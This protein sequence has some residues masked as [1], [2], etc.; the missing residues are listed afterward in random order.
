MV[1]VGISVEGAT[2]ERFIK[3]V[4][5]PYL[6]QKQIELT[7]INLKGNVSLNKIRSELKNL[8]F[9]F[10][11]VSTFYDFYGFNN[12]DPKETKATLE[13]NI[14][15]ATHDSIKTKLIP[16]IQMHEFEGLLF[17]SPKAISSVL[18]NEKL[19]LWAIE[20][21]KGFNNNPEQINNSV[22]TAPSKLLE[23][24]TRYRKTTH[25]PNIAKEIGIENIRNMCKGFNEWLNQ[26]EALAT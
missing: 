17:S 6:Y 22:D 13:E 4:L 19:E 3:S 26:L 12:K 10:D 18:N 14:L 24:N 15:N 21:L 2:E 1:R 5:A 11:Y 23:K 9:S 7:P 25:G 16:Y 8:A 20:I